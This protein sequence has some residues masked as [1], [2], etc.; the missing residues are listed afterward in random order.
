MEM[1]FV[2]ISNVTF[3]ELLVIRLIDAMVWNLGIG[4]MKVD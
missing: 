1:S 2:Q 4:G 3:S